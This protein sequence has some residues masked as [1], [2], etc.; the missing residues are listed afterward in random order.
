MVSVSKPNL[1]VE[2]LDPTLIIISLTYNTV[3]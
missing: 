2:Y 1:V 3:F